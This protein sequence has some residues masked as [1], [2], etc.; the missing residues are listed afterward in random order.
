MKTKIAIEHFGGVAKLAEALKISKTAVYLW[1][2]ELPEGRAFQLEVIT[3]G[4][5]K[6]VESTPPANPQEAAA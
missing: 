1:G 3:E 2:D 5:L 4:K 6:A